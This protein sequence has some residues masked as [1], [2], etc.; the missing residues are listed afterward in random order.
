MDPVSKGTLGPGGIGLS[1]QPLRR[2]R[3]ENDK[4]TGS[5]GNPVRPCLKR[6]RTD[7]P[8]GDRALAK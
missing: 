8:L 2:L 4:F 3:Q 1:S 6:K 5:L 7:L